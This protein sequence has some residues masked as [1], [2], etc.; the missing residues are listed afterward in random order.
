MS[1]LAAGFGAKLAQGQTLNQG[2]AAMQQGD[3]FTA[4]TALRRLEQAGDPEASRMLQDLFLTPSAPEVVHS[5]AAPRERAVPTPRQRAAP[6]HAPLRA[7]RPA[8]RPM[9]QDVS[10][11]QSDG[12]PDPLTDQSFREVDDTLARIGHLL[13]FDPILSGNKDVA[14]A[15]CHHPRLAAGD[16]VSLGLGTGA[17]GLGEARTPEG[18]HAA[19]R[20]IPRN[21]PALWNLGARDVRTLFHDGR[22]EMTPDTPGRFLTPQGPLDYMALDSLL[23]A[24]AMFP[25]LSPEEMAGRP[26]ENPIADAVAAERIHGDDGA[27][28]L[29]AARVDGLSAYRDVFAAWRGH[30][31]P[32]TM[33]EIANALAAFIEVEFRADKTPFD[34]YLREV[35]ALSAQAGEG[36]R[37]F[38]GRANCASCHSGPLLSDQKFHAM[39]QP[40]IGPGKERDA[41]GYTRDIG[42]AAVTL[43][44]ADAYAFRT[45]MLRN[46]L[47]TGPWGH[48]GAFAD[49]HAFL[50]HHLDP[51]AGLAAYQ[52]QAVLPDLGPYADDY[53]ATRDAHQ[54]E[55]ITSAAARAMAQRPLVILQDDEI[56]LLISFLETLDDPVALQGRF[57]VPDAVPSGLDIPD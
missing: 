21:A 38:Y 30:S 18:P 57:G 5:V 6:S 27:W 48:A 31:A 49:L 43:D 36:M 41:D 2:Y 29:L 52:P 24:Q 26:G 3:F 1:S 55:L 10:H 11:S 33:D 28:A 16:G 45:P 51:V 37:L 53:A 35:A 39:G 46:V 47:Q 20:R 50:R 15:T 34:Q 13:F 4:F 44:P 12:L 40:P 17:Q 56:S 14:C 25:V 7:P 54:R 32:V 19:V 8:P 9:R 22:V 42:R 23:A